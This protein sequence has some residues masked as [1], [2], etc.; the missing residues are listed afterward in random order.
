MSLDEAP[1]AWKVWAGSTLVLVLALI[2]TPSE[3]DSGDICPRPAGWLIVHPTD[4]SADVEDFDIG[5]YC[6][7]AAPKRGLAGAAVALLGTAITIGSYRRHP[8]SA[9][10]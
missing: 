9:D 1:P 8:E 7:D 10:S 4:E 5:R 2:A 3:V 6:N